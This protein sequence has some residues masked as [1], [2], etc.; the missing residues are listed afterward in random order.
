VVL[1]A[2]LKKLEADGNVRA[3]IKKA[4]DETRNL[5]VRRIEEEGT[6]IIRLERQ[7][8]IDPHEDERDV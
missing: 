1:R 7:L 3:V 2:D 5:L 6:Q 4:M 8:G